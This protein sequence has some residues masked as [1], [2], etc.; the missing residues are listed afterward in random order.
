MLTLLIISRT[1]SIFE[2]KK[3][4]KIQLSPQERSYP[5]QD[6]LHIIDKVTP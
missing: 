3:K 5:L 6:A 2:K 4:K 1:K